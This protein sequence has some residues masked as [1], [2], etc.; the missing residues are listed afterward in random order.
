MQRG[1]KEGARAWQGG[2]KGQPEVS[3]LNQGHREKGK[4]SPVHVGT[5]WQAIRGTGRG[6]QNVATQQMGL[7]IPPT[8]GTWD[9]LAV[10][11]GYKL[12]TPQDERTDPCSIARKVLAWGGQSSCRGSE[13]VPCHDEGRE[14]ETWMA[15]NPRSG[16]ASWTVPKDAGRAPDVEHWSSIELTRAAEAPTGVQV[17]LLEVEAP[18]QGRD[19]LHEPVSQPASEVQTA[20]DAPARPSGQAQESDIWL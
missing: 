13:K 4:E 3:S 12:E 1:I 7:T 9:R 11:G 8:G 15:Q 19:W 20:H 6:G 18:I 10:F 14:G 2:S 17:K 5:G 16:S